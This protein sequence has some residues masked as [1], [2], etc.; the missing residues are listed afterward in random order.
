[1]KRILAAGLVLVMVL[2]LGACGGAQ[3]VIDSVASALNGDVTGEVGKLYSTEWFDFNVEKLITETSYA[4]VDADEGYTFLVA[5]VY[6]LND[7][8]GEDDIPMSNYDFYALAG[9]D[10]SEIAP[11]DAW[12]EGM[13]PDVF[14]LA[15]E[16][17]ATY[18][19]VFM[20]PDDVESVKFVY[21]EMDD[22]GGT[23]ATF[24][25]EHDL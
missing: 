20:V 21:V 1:M 25:I 19:V 4:G 18:D 3:G 12:D 6:E 7:W 24:T 13:M 8:A 10:S 14:Y 5:T 16:E 2:G 17:E 11:E 22:Q 15:P 23:H 9:D